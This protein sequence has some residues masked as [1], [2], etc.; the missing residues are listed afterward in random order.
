MYSTMIKSVLLL[1]VFIAGQSLCLAEESRGR[2][3]TFLPQWIPQSQFAGY[4]VA[5]EKGIYQKYNLDVT[6][7]RGGPERPALHALESGEADFASTFLSSAIESRARDMPIRNIGQL[8][9]KSSLVLVSKKDSGIDHPEKFDGKKISIW[10]DFAVQPTALF[11]K[12]N[13]DVTII[14]QTYTLTLFLR[15]GVDVASAMWYNEYHTLLNSGYNED[16]LNLFFYDDYGLNFPED[17][18]YCLEETLIRDRALCQDF[19]RASL[20]GW[21]YAFAHPDEAV[22]MVLK[23]VANANLPTSRV[24]Q[25]WMLAR[26]KDIMLPKDSDNPLGRLHQDDYTV[27]ATELL[28]NGSIDHIPNYSEFYENCATQ[29]QEK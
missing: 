21:R 27:V 23:Y 24:H 10:P 22:D 20:E 16:E 28:Q 18:I 15:G 4:Y 9:Q 8:V 3:V 6:I 11:R 7:L 13:L 17:G 12:Y 2:K 19:V 25:E 29:S 14:P 1:I 5:Y 26:M